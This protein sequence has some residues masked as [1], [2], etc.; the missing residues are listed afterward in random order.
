V[1]LRSD[2][3]AR[4]AKAVA[5]L[6][7]EGPY[8]LLKRILAFLVSGVAVDWTLYLYEHSLVERDRTRYLPRLDAWQLRVIHSNDEADAVA[9]GGFEDF[10]KAVRPARRR[11]QAGAVA[12]CVYVGAELA[13]VGWLALDQAGKD[14][15]DRVP[16]GVAFASGQACTGGTYT[17]PKYRGH[18]LMP[19][20]YYVRLEY[21]RR[22]G[23]TTS[24]NVVGVSNV[25]SQKAHAGFDPAIRGIGHY[26]RVLW[27]HSWRE[28]PLPDGPCRGMP[29]SRGLGRAGR[30]GGGEP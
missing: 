16:Y 7:E 5:V 23:F 17:V 8:R 10:R 22:K 20:G 4:A 18:R 1:T 30:L 12:F 25:A 21:L 29:P 19:Y 6:R 28:E 13:H 24:R 11:L 27:W 2:T 14:S 3:S 15:F 26:R 9:A